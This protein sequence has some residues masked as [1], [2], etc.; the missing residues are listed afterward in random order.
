M[1]TIHII[2]SHPRLLNVAVYWAAST[3]LFHL[4]ICQIMQLFF[5]VFCI[6]IFVVLKHFLLWWKGKHNNLPGI[7][8]PSSRY[9][10]TDG[11]RN[12]LGMTGSSSSSIW[13]LS[14]LWSGSRTDVTGAPAALAFLALFERMFC[15]C[16]CSEPSVME[17]KY[18]FTFFYV[19][20]LNGM[21]LLKSF[22]FRFSAKIDSKN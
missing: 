21:D 19:V 2:H 20:H 6:M 16:C 8:L 11:L 15:C 7:D 9:S 18:E 4:T 5:R 12:T 1:A 22:F 13:S 10:L 17:T 3:T 14:I